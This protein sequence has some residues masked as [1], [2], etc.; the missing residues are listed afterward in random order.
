MTSKAPADRA[1]DNRGTVVIVAATAGSAISVLVFQALA[2]RTLGT[3]GFAP[4]A[5]M[6]TVMFLLFTI[7]L[8]PA[9]QHL[10]RALVVTRDRE[11]LRGVYRAMMAA[12]ALA[13][14]LGVGFT[15]ATLDRFFDG[16]AVFVAITAAIVIAR[17]IMSTARG[18]LAD[19]RRFAG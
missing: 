19:H 18:S 10:T 11:D 17:S 9:E 8:L 4:I 7:L 2:S 13:L 12:F 14:V 1:R 16:D 15:W 6:W 5:V 3:D